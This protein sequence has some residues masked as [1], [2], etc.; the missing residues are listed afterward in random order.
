MTT[1]T[2]LLPYYILC[3]YRLYLLLLDYVGCYIYTGLLVTHTV[4]RSFALPHA[5]RSRLR[6]FV[7]AVR[8][9]GCRSAAALHTYTHVTHTH[10]YHT[11]YVTTT[12]RFTHLPRLHIHTRLRYVAVTH[13]THVYHTHTTHVY[14]LHSLLHTHTHHITF[15]VLPHRLLPRLLPH[16]H[17]HTT[18]YTFYLCSIAGV[19]HVTH[20]PHYTLLPFHICCCYTHL[21][22]CCCCCYIC[23]H[24]FG[25]R[26]FLHVYVPYRAVVRL[27][28]Y[29]AHTRGCV[30]FT[31]LLRTALHAR[32]R[33]TVYTG[34]RVWFIPATRSGRSLRIPRSTYGSTCWLR[35]YVCSTFDLRTVYRLVTVTHAVGSP[36]CSLRFVRLPRLPLHCHVCHTHARS[37][38]TL[39]LP[40]LLRTRLFCVVGSCSAFCHTFGLLPH[41]LRSRLP[42]HTL[43][44]PGSA[45]I[46]FCRILPYCDYGSAGST[47]GSFTHCS[48]ACAC[49]VLRLVLPLRYAFGYPRFPFAVVIPRYTCVR[50]TLPT[51]YVYGC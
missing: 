11:H 35:F 5:P 40:T 47:F 48:S 12:V 7:L 33:F 45:V 8:T 22:F 49:T 15:W 9:T 51:R 10:V 26:A 46:W 39:R 13:S 36:H 30:Y 20:V 4:L 2:R 27:V 43:V 21:R 28:T 1:H 38:R 42:P 3:G 16:T 17:I 32:I 6:W 14:V 34:L 25:L 23:L 50:V 41:V 24:T 44:L 31:A 29:C 37:G 18:R 19:T